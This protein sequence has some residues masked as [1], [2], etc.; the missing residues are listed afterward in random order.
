MTSDLNA[1]QSL[2]INRWHVVLGV[3]LLIWIIIILC[4]STVPPVSRDAL[5]HHLRVPQLYI[6]QKGLV[7][8]PNIVFSY[9]PMNL[10]LLYLI[11]LLWGND[12]VPKYIHFAFALGTACL[13]FCYLNRRLGS[14][15]GW[16]GALLFLSLPVIIKL[17]ITVYVDLGLVFFFTAAILQLLHWIEARGKRKY[18][19]FAGVFCGLG[20]GTKYNGLIGLLLFAMLI[21]MMRV[22]ASLH[23][24]PD[25]KSGAR[26]VGPMHQLT[27]AGIDLIIFTAV[28]LLVFS[29][30]MIR[31]IYWQGN[32]LYP[33][34]DGLFSA[35]DSI[36][37]PSLDPL[38]TRRLLYGETLWQSLLV[39]LRVFF[40][41]Q[42]NNP[43]LFDGRLSPLLLGLPL[44]AFTKSREASS[45]LKSQ[46]RGLFFFSALYVL[47]A[48]F[49]TDMRI[50]YILPIVPPLIILSAYGLNTLVGWRPNRWCAKYGIAA[51]SIIGAACLLI[52]ALQ[53]PYLRAQ[54][55]YVDPLPYMTGAI[56]SA[57][58]IVK[59]RP[60]YELYQYGNRELDT[61]AKVLALFLGNRGYRFKREIEFDINWFRSAL[62]GVKSHV[63]LSR[64]VT[65][66]GYTHLMINHQLFNNWAHT[67]CNDAE[68]QVLASFLDLDTRPVY[69]TGNGH[70][71]YEIQPRLALHR[72]R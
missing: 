64:R 22:W 63:E 71:L 46:K 49:M 10:D 13:L 24:A 12:I 31:N 34:F 7:E 25:R 44:L 72:V 47:I 70:I 42:D 50:R 51:P 18:L 9:Y 20:L 33:L 68:Q 54:W 21:P 38:S 65:D 67:N 14:M 45:I 32:P 15:Y 16:F 23:E 62:T 60:E 5:T 39:P 19:V 48:L 2:S 36:R 37:Q 11:P 17:S 3:L 30:W 52:V 53:M 29:P 41:G 69:K 4:M 8:L 59:Y 35:A 57:S 55:R 26:S 28:A 6:D 66:N 56:D 1:N 43:Q 27:V 40:E 58:Y 61:R